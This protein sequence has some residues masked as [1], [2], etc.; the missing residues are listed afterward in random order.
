MKNQLLKITTLSIL[1]SSLVFA[2]GY[3]IPE[4]SVNAVALSG[5]NVANTKGADTAYYN[6]ANMSF[7]EDS[8]AMDVNL[9]YIGL[10]GTKFEGSGTQAGDNI[11]AKSEN[12]IV[13]SINY[14]SPK[15]GDL[16][17]GFALV[18]PGGLTKRWNDSP[19]IDKA[20]EFS[21]TVIEL[22]PTISYALNNKL[23][24]AFGV[25]A[26]YSEGIVKSSSTASRDL[27]GT[28]WDFGYNL[29]LAY[30][31]TND[32]DIA[33][34]YRSNI[35][36]TEEGNAKLYIGNAK[37]Y[38]GGASV[39]V[40]LPAVLN[41]AI[42]YTLPTK[43][44]LEFV[45]ERAYWSSYKNLDFN[46]EDTIPLAIQ[47][48]MD[49]AISKDWKDVNIYRL[50]ITQNIDEYTLMAGIVYDETP[51]PDSK[52]SYE[53]PDSDSVSVSLGGRYQID[54]DLDLGMSIL[55]SIRDDRDVNNDEIEGT[56]S[57]SNIVLL[58]F[59]AGYK[60]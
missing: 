8:Q 25:R 1:S 30:K 7:M 12:F 41:L 51:V 48:P 29:A 2:G 37:V 15:Y 40:P 11:Q 47:E 54:K 56:F 6:P 20:E 50:G 14:V 21:L 59:G 52:V 32:L 22:N 49:G 18:V 23:S 19:A 17:Y 3:R 34:T 35:D 39:E 27:E 36:L 44:T 33:L 53:L 42:A 46:Y 13:P 4:T 10:D 58:A 45:Y 16:R 9:M 43:T 26:L 5:A 55:Y 28:S 38:D 60:F 24:L 57:N 31:P